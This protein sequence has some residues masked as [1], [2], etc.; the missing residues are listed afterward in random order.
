[1]LKNNLYVYGDEITNFPSHLNFGQYMVDI[2]WTNSDKVA[3]INGATHEKLTYRNIAEDAMNVAISLTRMGIRRGD[4]I[5]ICTENRQEY[6]GTFIGITCTGATFTAVSIA[7]TRDEMKHVL[8]ISKPKMIVCSPL[9]YKTHGETLKSLPFIEKV[10]LYG[11]DKAAN[12]LLYDN[13]IENGVK[14]SAKNFAAADVLGQTDTAVILYSSGTTGLPKG[15]MLTHLNIISICCLGNSLNPHELCMMITPWYHTMGLMGVV[16]NLA[17]GS[18]LVYLPKFDS[19]T[20]L[21]TIERY[22]VF[23]LIVPP[24]VI[25]TLNKTRGNYDVSSVKLVYS[26][27]APL[28]SDTIQQLRNRFPEVLHVLQGYGMTECTLSATRDTYETA[29]ITKT[30]SVGRIVAGIVIKVVD[31]ET[32]EP[33]GANQP[34]EICIKGPIIM[35]GYVGK[36]KSE[37]F[38]VEGFYKTGDIGYYDEDKYFFIV[39]RLKEL[40]KYKAYQVPPAEIEAV[41][42]EHPSILDAGVI[43]I[44]HDSAGEVPRAY[45]VLKSQAKL[46]EEDVKNFV[47]EK[48]SSPKHLRGGVHFISEIPKTPSGKILRRKLKEMAKNTE[49]KS[50]L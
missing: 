41:L 22:R 8:N 49:V 10:I 39:D 35:K 50:K 19:D 42:L 6:Y 33:L 7:Y 40:I 2:L 43:G 9:A 24:P 17:S 47:A 3:L 15:V 48:L 37:D 23:Q 16:R 1:M 26:G 13:L 29:H 32:R 46:S 5:A 18:S 36:D 4:T 27:G 11:K 44:P 21:K 20:Y 45:V 14:Y 25:V 28:R 12:T 38:D 30:G 34:G 31:I